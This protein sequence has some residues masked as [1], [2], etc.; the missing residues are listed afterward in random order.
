MDGCLVQFSEARYDLNV[1]IMVIFYHHSNIVAAA[2]GLET[3][4]PIKIRVT[5]SVRIMQSQ[6]IGVMQTPT[7]F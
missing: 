4:L 6:Y 7:Q 2:L 3:L 1:N 5:K